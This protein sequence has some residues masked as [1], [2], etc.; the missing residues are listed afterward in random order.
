MK[1]KCEVL[2]LV[3]EICSTKKT[4]RKDKVKSELKIS[5]AVVLLMGGKIKMWH[6]F[7]AC[8]PWSLRGDCLHVYI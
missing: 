3:L 1:Q 6:L 4:G 7:L 5:V 2:H 8:S